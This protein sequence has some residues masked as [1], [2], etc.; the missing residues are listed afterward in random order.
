M[1]EWRAWRDDYWARLVLLTRD[2]GDTQPLDFVP[3]RSPVI[4][5]YPVTDI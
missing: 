2:E 3:F 5:T 1:L 4:S